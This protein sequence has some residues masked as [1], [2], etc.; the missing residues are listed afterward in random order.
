[1]RAGCDQLR[2]TVHI[3]GDGTPEP[4]EKIHRTVMATS[5]NHRHLASAIPLPSRRVIGA[6][7][8]RQAA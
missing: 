4:F 7:A 6:E 8:T 2:C 3:R 1:V 5:P